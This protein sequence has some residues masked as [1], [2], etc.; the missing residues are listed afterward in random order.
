MG[1]IAS[2]I[3][4]PATHPHLVAI[5]AVF[6]MDYSPQKPGAR[7][8]GRPSSHENDKEITSESE[9]CEIFWK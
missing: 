8:D 4:E 7:R 1:V 5:A 2:R 3:N 6:A 9:R